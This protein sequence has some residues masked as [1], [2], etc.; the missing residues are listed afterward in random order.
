MN[1]FDWTYGTK[2]DSAIAQDVSLEEHDRRFHPTGYNEGDV[3]SLRDTANKEDALQIDNGSS[4]K[5]VSLLRNWLP[6]VK[7]VE[8]DSADSMQ[9]AL[10]DDVRAF[11]KK[12]YYERWKNMISDFRRGAW[13]MTTASGAKEIGRAHV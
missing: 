12:S 8:D 2:T 7:I 13:S 1:F 6:G 5:A 9:R 4:E 10:A 11:I 3:C